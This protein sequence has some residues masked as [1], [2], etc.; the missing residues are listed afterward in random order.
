MGKSRKAL[1]RLSKTKKKKLKAGDSKDLE[2]TEATSSSSST[3]EWI[4]APISTLT[5]SQTFSVPNI[6]A[7][8]KTEEVPVYV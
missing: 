3:S 7:T 1:L 5:E 2:M 6:F 8:E 4:T